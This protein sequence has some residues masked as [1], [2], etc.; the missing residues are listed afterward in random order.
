MAEPEKETVR[1]TP[2]QLSATNG[3]NVQRRF[4]GLSLNKALDVYAKVLDGEYTKIV[5]VSLQQALD[6]LDVG[7]RKM[8][9]KWT[10]YVATGIPQKPL[11]EYEQ[12]FDKI[13]AEYQDTRRRLVNG[14]SR[15]QQE[16]SRA[17]DRAMESDD[18]DE[19]NENFVPKVQSAFRPDKLSADASMTTFRLWRDQFTSYFKMSK[20]HKLKIQQQQTTFYGCLTVDLARKVRVVAMPDTPVLGEQGTL[21]AI[22][23]A[24][25]EQ[26]NPILAR[27]VNFFSLKQQQGEKTSDY[28][29]RLQETGLAAELVKIKTP[30]QLMSLVFLAHTKDAEVK[31]LVLQAG[32]EPE[33]AFIMKMIANVEMEKA[34]TKA[35]NPSANA[36]QS[37][38]RSKSRGRSEDRGRSS[39]RSPSRARSKSRSRP[40]SKGRSK[41][42]GQQPEADACWRCGEDG[43]V[44]D[45]CKESQ[46]KLFCQNCKKKGHATKACFRNRKKG[47][48]NDRPRQR[49]QSPSPDRRGRFANAAVD[50]VCVESEPV[51]SEAIT[52]NEIGRAAPKACVTFTANG[53]KGRRPINFSCGEVTADTGASDTVFKSR[54]LDAIGVRYKRYHVPMAAANGNGL[55]IIGRVLLQASYMGFHTEVD[56]LVCS[57]LAPT[58]LLGWD[59]CK[60][61]RMISPDFPM[62]IERVQHVGQR[63]QQLD[64]DSSSISSSSSDDGFISEEEVSDCMH[65][66]NNVTAEPAE[67]KKDNQKGGRVQPD[68]AP[69]QEVAGEAK[70][71]DKISADLGELNPFANCEINAENCAAMMEMMLRK[72]SSVFSDSLKGKETIR[73]ATMRINLKPGYK[74]LNVTVAKATPIHCKDK[75]DNLIRTLIK[76][77]VIEKVPMNEPSE[78]CSRT[79]F[80]P[81]SNGDVRMVTDFRCLNQAVERAPKPFP[82]TKDIIANLEPT[83]KVYA[84]TDA[85]NGY[86]QL[87]LHKDSRPYTTFIIDSGRY[88]YLRGPMGCS[89]TG[90]SFCDATDRA[91]HGHEGT[92]KIVDDGLT[93]GATMEEL[94]SRLDS[95]LE[96]CKYYRIIL[97]KKKFNVAEKVKFAGHVIGADGVQPDPEKTRAITNFPVP[98][99]VTEV[100]SFLGLAN[101]LASFVPDLTQNARPIHALTKKDTAFVWGHEQQEAFEN[102][103]K[104]LTS[105][106]LVK[107]FN[108][109]FKT[110]L[111]TDASRLGLGYLLCQR[112]DK[113]ELRLVRCG[114]R[115]LAA[116]EKNYG[117]TE[118]EALAVSFACNHCS[119]YLQGAPQFDVITDHRA[120]VPMWSQ[121]LPEMKNARCQKFRERL[122]H[123]NINMV[124]KA[125]KTHL[126][127]DAL[128]RFPCFLP[129]E[130]EKEKSISMDKVVA[131]TVMHELATIDPSQE[132]L[133]ADRDQRYL[134]LIDAVKNGRIDSSK[135]LNEYKES[136]NELSLIGKPGNNLVIKDGFKVVVPAPARKRVLRALHAGHCGTRKTQSLAAKAVFWPGMNNDIKNQCEACPQCLE[137][138]AAQQKET[139]R[140]PEREARDLAPMSDVGVD[141]FQCA[142]KDFLL[143]VDRFSGYP[144]VQKLTTTTTKAVTSVLSQWFSLFGYPQRIRSDGGPQF[145]GPFREYCEDKQ[146]KHELAAA[147]N[148]SSNG[149]AENAVKQCKHLLIKCIEEGS[150]YNDALL[151]W[152]QTPKREG[153]PSPANLFLHRD[154][155]VAGLPQSTET[156]QFTPTDQMN[157]WI[158]DRQKQFEST[159]DQVDNRGKDLPPLEI[160]IRVD[161]KKPNERGWELDAADIFDVREDGRSYVLREA[162]SKRH[163]VRPRYM[164]REAN[165]ENA[166]PEGIIQPQK[167]CL[168]PPS[169]DDESGPVASRT[170][171]KKR[172]RFA[173]KEGEE[174]ENGRRIAAISNLAERQASRLYQSVASFVTRAPAFP[175]S[176]AAAAACPPA[177]SSSS[178]PPVSAP[179]PARRTGVTASR[180]T[181]TDPGCS[182]RCPK[183]STSR[184]RQRSATARTL[185]TT[186]TATGISGRTASAWPSTRQSSRPPRTCTPT[187]P[188][189]WGSSS[190]RSRASSARPSSPTS[191]SCPP[192]GARSRRSPGRSSSSS[193]PDAGPSSGGRTP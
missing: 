72:F 112:D 58:C 153:G 189:P 56:A 111:Y 119:F 188:A 68:Q 145:Q 192:W 26:Q 140:Q 75:A 81:K 18:D 32:E 30:D 7:W 167:C 86:F 178:S 67:E 115:S 165:K 190:S 35:A 93:G 148:P 133:L 128:S 57:N 117:V 120:L 34:A 82:S 97:S 125:G 37:R 124:W 23:A 53:K 41:S 55:D 16:R 10:S 171:S 61:L 122:Q 1:L 101:Q 158:K 69:K 62:A 24:A 70:T 182:G 96:D 45:D 151:T 107:P 19:D 127:A 116:A 154:L 60:K 14:I 152:R 126:M 193:W 4:F 2:A 46:S 186:E 104:L 79:M 160:G 169:E 162:K 31:R 173:G 174:C 138:K 11:A 114:S 49:S 121:P 147:Y 181:A 163:F 73:D 33:L 110:E 76:D 25:I 78:W 85:L 12:T 15:I 175:V 172:V 36:T 42:R 9:A 191:C 88:R 50:Y 65:E 27:W 66:E 77:E 99:S 95:L 59:D 129:Q 71:C 184:P 177:S 91:F 39:R 134:D 118:L 180:P 139:S 17:K 28:M 43:H 123:F 64:D 94:Y 106:L 164:L 6:E 98:T 143:M 74:P 170:R 21:E 5:E 100:R 142:G 54:Y 155:N 144:F 105:D 84:T 29:A 113:D 90:D 150:D 185:T 159:K 157:E 38:G 141:L 146:I 187:S 52:I 63:M 87:P 176:F 13:Q 20:F 89:Q 44:R 156:L 47:K 161:V 51:A 137:L 168:L 80:V 179:P 8:E 132:T 136:F 109:D 135:D 131:L 83:A 102:V 108:K 103:K 48:K 149:L 40:K 166:S 3:L 130:G 22:V 183:V 92:Q